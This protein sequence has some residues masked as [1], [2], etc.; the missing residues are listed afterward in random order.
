MVT[1]PVYTKILIYLYWASARI[2][3]ILRFPVD[4][5]QE[6]FL[7][8][9]Q[10]STFSAA[11]KC[12]FSAT[13]KMVVSKNPFTMKTLLGWVINFLDP[14]ELTHKLQQCV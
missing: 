13:Q 12:N 4:Q 10:E 14:V 3:L 5:D 7:M 11:E 1:L 2:F 9:T 6:Q 8:I